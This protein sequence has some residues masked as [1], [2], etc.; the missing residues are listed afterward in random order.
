MAS[1]WKRLVPPPKVVDNSSF[2]I[3]R[4]SIL[5]LKY[6]YFC[7]CFAYEGVRKNAL[8]GGTKCFH[9]DAMASLFVPKLL[10]H[11]FKMLE[12]LESHPGKYFSLDSSSFEI[13][14]K[15]ILEL[16]YSY[17]CLCFAYEGVRKK[18]LVVVRNASTSMPWLR[19]LSLNYLNMFSKR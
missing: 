19:F 7:L 3:S 12:V 11:I 9:M 6:S 15:S 14:A 17:F 16:K 8:G 2:E 18:A 4:K 1:M 5:E 13:W 10:K